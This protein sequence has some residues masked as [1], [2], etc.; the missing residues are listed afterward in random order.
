MPPK[1]IGRLSVLCFHV[2]VVSTGGF[3][4]GPRRGGPHMDRKSQVGQTQ[5]PQGR[6][7]H[8]KRVSRLLGGFDFACGIRMLVSLF[9]LGSTSWYWL[10]TPYSALAPCLPTQGDSPGDCAAWRRIPAVAGL[11]PRGICGCGHTLCLPHVSLQPGRGQLTDASW[12]L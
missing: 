2:R 5:S 12:N 10:L 11:A 6:K 9:P 8:H 1:A 4:P 3:Q 7:C